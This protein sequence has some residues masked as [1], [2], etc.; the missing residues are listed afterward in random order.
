MEDNE[1]LRYRARNMFGAI[2]YA[3]EA[4]AKINSID[5]AYS[6]YFMIGSEKAS[7]IVSLT[8]DIKRQIWRLKQLLEQL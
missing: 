2:E 1:L 6:D 4:H 5:E 7:E 8:L 3:K